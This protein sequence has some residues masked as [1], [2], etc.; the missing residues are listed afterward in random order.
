M[1][2]HVVGER[3]SLLREVRRSRMLTLDGNVGGQEAERRR[4]SIAGDRAAGKG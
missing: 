2:H 4:G 1:G 3:L